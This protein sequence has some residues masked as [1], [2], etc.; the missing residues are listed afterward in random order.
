MSSNMS[1]NS[2]DSNNS[3]GGITT[4]T[5]LEAQILQ[6]F[7]VQ[8]D[9]WQVQHGQKADKIEV[10]YYPEDDGFDV[11]NNEPN[12]G[13]I[14]RTRTTAFRADIIGWATNQLN[15][16]RGWDN[17][18][19]VLAFVASYKDNKFGVA[20]KCADDTSKNQAPDAL[21]APANLNTFAKVYSNGQD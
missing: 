19:T 17:S 4:L 15:I 8:V 16:L 5:R 12:H 14:K 13:I 21:D 9:A 18:N 11:L 1:N 20:V 7:I 6:S 3:N 10:I 2:N